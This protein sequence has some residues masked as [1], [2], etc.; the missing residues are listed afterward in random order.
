MAKWYIRWLNIGI[1]TFEFPLAIS[2]LKQWKHLTN[3][4]SF[5]TQTILIAFGGKLI[6][7][8]WVNCF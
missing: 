1:L 6:L 4:T 2:Q 3:A 8:P 7:I 5:E